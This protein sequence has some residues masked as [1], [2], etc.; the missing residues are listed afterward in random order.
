VDGTGSESCP[1]TIF[2]TSDVKDSVSAATDQI[3]LVKCKGLNMEVIM[4]KQ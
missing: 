4:I 2:G 3:T 1:M